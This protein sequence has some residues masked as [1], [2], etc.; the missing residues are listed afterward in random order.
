MKKNT[1]RAFSVSTA[2]GLISAL[3][4]S[5]CASAPQ[6]DEPTGAIFYPSPPAPARLQYLTKFSSQLDLGEKN[7]AFRDFVFGDETTEGHLVNKP[8]GLAVFE[9]IGRA[10]V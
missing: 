10:H 6:S 2:V 9:E 1:T 7:E 8:Y 4:L 5:A 3:I